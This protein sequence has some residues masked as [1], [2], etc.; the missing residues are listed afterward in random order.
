MRQSAQSEGQILMV[1]AG[2]HHVVAGVLAIQSSIRPEF[3]EMIKSLKQPAIKTYV[4]SA[5]SEQRT[6][7]LTKE[8]GVDFY[9]AE[10]LAE[11]KA[12][13]I[14]Q[15]IDDGKF[16]CFVGDGINDAIALRSAHIPPFRSKAYPARRPTPRKSSLWAAP[17]LHRISYSS[18][19]GI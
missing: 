1:Y 15:L 13:I 12:H 7:S 5:K 11:N 16:G 17:W 10:T 3:L 4:I 14:K 19:G 2:I 18:H 9:F 6:R 8:L